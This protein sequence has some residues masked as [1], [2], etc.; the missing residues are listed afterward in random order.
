[1]TY[2]SFIQRYHYNLKTDRLGEGGFGEVFKVFDTHLDRYV[3]LK[4]AKVKE[5]QPMFRLKKEVDIAAKLPTH[6]NI[7]RYE[8]CYTFETPT[9]TFDFAILQYYEEGNLLK[10]IRDKSLSEQQKSGLID[11]ILQ[12]IQ[13]L[14]ENNI[15]HRDLKPQNILIARRGDTFIPKI[16]DFGISKQLNS[17]AESWISNS[18][19]GGSIG[20]AS[21]EQLR[22]AKL[23]QKNT[24]LWSMGVLIYQIIT[25]ELPF[26]TG[27][28]D[29]G[30]EQGRMEMA[31]QIAEGVLPG[32]IS[33]IPT[34]FQQMIRRCML[35]DPVQRV[36]QADQLLDILSGKSECD[37]KKNG[38]IEDDLT[39]I[40][41][42]KDIVPMADDKENI[43][44]K[45]EIRKVSNK[46][47]RKKFLYYIF[48]GCFFICIAFIVALLTHTLP[49]KVKLINQIPEFEMVYVQGGTFQ[50]GSNEG[51]SDERPVHQVTVN[52]FYIG[53]FEITQEQWR[54]VM[55][56]DPPELYFKGCDNCPVESVC[57][58]DVQVFIIKV[59]EI[60]DKKYR[61]PTEAEWE[62]AARGGNRSRGF[63]YAG[64]NSI[65]DVAWY[66]SKI[67][68]VGKKV[69]NELGIYDMSG[70]VCE[71]C[72]DWYADDYYTNSPR[73]NPE[74]TT[75]SSGRVSRGGSF[76]NELTRCRV[77]S[78]YYFSPAFRYRYLGFRLA[79]L[80]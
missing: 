19:V 12:G 15:I 69:S 55:G 72:D 8:A 4:I 73:Y 2:E 21:P 51:E 33:D 10:L 68:P 7:A 80:E 3:A 54:A 17:E 75:Q 48:T 57:W 63:T 29:S 16:S 70:N 1:M 14:H 50:M 39:K 26:N 35:V 77:A 46:P 20:Y 62:Y 71:W 34:P 79:R 38:Q 43:D 61:L 18:L 28:Y 37:V 47:N 64:S 5:D 40:F 78:R 67:H 9:G 25:G 6:A 58:N 27:L 11:K 76:F 23:I 74:N 52:S 13:F 24:D 41:P 66:Y 42:V 31:R 22:G 44:I 32:K 49:F 56:S 65:M 36:K 60:S 45:E 53:K 59:N 30:S